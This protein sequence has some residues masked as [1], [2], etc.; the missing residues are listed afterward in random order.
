MSYINS[1]DR[2]HAMYIY[3]ICSTFDGDFNLVVWVFICQI[4][5]TYCLHFV[6]ISIIF[7]RDL[8]NPCCQAKYQFAKPHVHQMYH[9]YNICIYCIHIYV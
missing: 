4:K 8:D 2:F 6:H 3:R 7:L 9:V 1:I 5:C